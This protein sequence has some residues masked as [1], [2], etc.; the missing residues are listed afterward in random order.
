MEEAAESAPFLVA[1]IGGGDRIL[2]DSPHEGIPKM[3]NEYKKH[4]VKFCHDQNVVSFS[5]FLSFHLIADEGN[6]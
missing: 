5:W 6:A 3:V 2:E 4:E 1:G